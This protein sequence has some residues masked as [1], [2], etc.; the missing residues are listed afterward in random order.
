MIVIYIPKRGVIIERG[1]YMWKKLLAAL[2]FVALAAYG[3]YLLF[4]EGSLL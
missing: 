3:I 1:D 4:F 2:P